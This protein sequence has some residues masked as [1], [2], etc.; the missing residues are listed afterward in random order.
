MTGILPVAT[1]VLSNASFILL[2]TK[3]PLLCGD[4]SDFSSLMLWYLS[5]CVLRRNKPVILSL[6][7][8]LIFKFI[9][10]PI[11][12]II[13][14]LPALPFHRAQF[15]SQFQHYDRIIFEMLTAPW[16][17]LIGQHHGKESVVSATGLEVI[18]GST[19]LVLLSFWA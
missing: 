14:L 5:L 3:L 9:P 19:C 13:L 16:S 18:C 7:L 8:L 4:F 1:C 17:P 10:R 6:S 12:S 2:L 11:L 15:Y